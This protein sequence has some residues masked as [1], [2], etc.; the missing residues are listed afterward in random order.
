VVVS[1][2]T[3]NPTTEKGVQNRC[4]HRPNFKEGL[5]EKSKLTQQINVQGHR[6]GWDE[7]R[8]LG[9]ESNSRYRNYNESVLMARFTTAISINVAKC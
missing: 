3:D 2:N 5:L 1:S 6:V 9:I 4:K 8:I 7:D